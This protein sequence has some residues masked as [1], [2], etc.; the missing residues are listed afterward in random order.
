[1]YSRPRDL[2]HHAHGYMRHGY[3]TSE[4][5]SLSERPTNTVS[6]TRTKEALER[7]I[8]QNYFVNRTARRPSLPSYFTNQFPRMYQRDSTPYSYQPLTMTTPGYS[9][10]VARRDSVS[11]GSPYSGPYSIYRRT[12][13]MQSPHHHQNRRYAYPAYQ[14]DGHLPERRH[15]IRPRHRHHN[16]LDSGW[17]NLQRANTLP[18]PGLGPQHHDASLSF[19]HPPSYPQRGVHNHGRPGPY[20]TRGPSESSSHSVR[21]GEYHNYDYDSA[22]IPPEPVYPDSERPGFLDE[23]SLSMTRS[24]S[25]SSSSDSALTDLLPGA[26]SFHPAEMQLVKYDPQARGQPEGFEAVEGGIHRDYPEEI[27]VGGTDGLTEWSGAGTKGSET[28]ET[29]SVRSSQDIYSDTSA[30]SLE[31]E[32]YEESFDSRSAYENYRGGDDDDFESDEEYM[33]DGIASDEGDYYWSDDERD[34]GDWEDSV[35]E[36][37][38]LDEESFDEDELGERFGR[39]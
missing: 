27:S 36:E 5:P 25:A 37:G 39:L 30:G 1:M 19:S 7:D 21:T 29:L 35:Y 12:H 10:S 11:S 9:G 6:T 16:S 20:T 3:A 31:T 18:S 2:L 26:P 14:D 17:P 22:G 33:S 34:L 15:P 24:P 23:G 32:G 13:H 38:T 4:F 28:N 8:Q